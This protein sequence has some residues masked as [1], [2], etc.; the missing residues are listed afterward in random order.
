ARVA[1]AL[2]GSLELLHPT[3][4][5]PR[6]IDVTPPFERC[7]IREA[8]ARFA[9]VDDAVGLALQDETRF[10]EILVNE[11]EPALAE[12]SRPVFLTHYPRSQ[13]SLARSCPRDPTVAER[14]ELYV[15]GV[16]LC[17]GFSE[18]TDP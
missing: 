16:E 10:F 1:R 8:F 2:R 3:G 18:L 9:R 11:V 12:E 17:N 13:A 15:A 14:F 4:G 6:V 5:T 7:T